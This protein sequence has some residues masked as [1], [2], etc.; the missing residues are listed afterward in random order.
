[1]RGVEHERRRVPLSQV[2][3]E[4]KRT[5]H[6]VKLNQPD[7]SMDSHSLALSVELK[8][9]GLSLYVILNAYWEALD[10][11]LPVV[12]NGAE[13]WRRWIDTALDPPQ[14]I[15]EWH[16]GAPVL[17]GT[18]RAGPRSVVVLIAGEALIREHLR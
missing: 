14:E 12:T 9:E 13:N 2:L 11:E 5:W 18:Y 15:C 1:M 4:A 3:R 10:F 16:A 8:D 17:A 7:W 6:G